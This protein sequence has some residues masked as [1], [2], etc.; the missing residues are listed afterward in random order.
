VK[1][2]FPPQHNYIQ[3]S[4]LEPQSPDRTS[5]YFDSK[6]G[7]GLLLKHSI[8]LNYM[9]P[10]TSGHSEVEILHDNFA[11]AIQKNSNIVGHVP[12]EFSRPYW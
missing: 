11:V 8:S 1:T 6:V 2:W 4:V 10:Q 3:A 9:P 5:P 7:R 12:Q